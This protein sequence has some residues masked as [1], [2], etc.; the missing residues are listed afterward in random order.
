MNLAQKAVLQA[1][2]DAG[3]LPME[4]AAEFMLHDLVQACIDQMRAQTKVYNDLGQ[5]QQDAVNA[6]LQSDLKATVYTAASIL[7]GAEVIQV[8]LLLQ[9]LD[10][11]KELKLTGIIASDDPGRYQ[12]M[13]MAHKKQKAIILL[14]DMNYFQGLDNIQADR[15]QKSLPLDDAP[16]PAGKGGK[17][18]AAPKVESPTSAKAIA[19]KP[20]EL[21]EK[22]VADAIEFVKKQQV[23]GASSLQN[24]LKIG[25]PKAK[26]VQAKLAELGH[27]ALD[28]KGEYQIVRATKVETKDAGSTA[29]GGDTP[30]SFDDDDAPKVAQVLTDELYAEIKTKVI[31]DGR[32]SV[33]A[34]AVAFDI[35]TDLVETAID[36]LELDGVISPVDDELGTRT[37]LTNDE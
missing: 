8:P 28:D 1:A 10:T 21:P 2:K 5:Q 9:K 17:G 3:L 29:G 23:C 27:I 24:H 7:V 11:G 37:V 33:G 31:L 18:K 36:R 22:L 19:A 16:A 32:V 6:K 12:L 35:E 25:G 34:L 26:A 30:L 14:H 20:I 15:D 4:Q 13:D